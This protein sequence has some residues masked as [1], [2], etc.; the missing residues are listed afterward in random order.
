VPRMAR[1]LAPG[2][3]QTKR[4]P[5]DARDAARPARDD[6]RDP[7]DAARPTRDDVRD[8]RD[9]ARPTH[10]GA[11]DPRDLARPARDPRDAGRPTRDPRDRAAVRAEIAALERELAA[12]PLLELPAP[13]MGTARLLTMAELEAERARLE[14][15]LTRARGAAAAQGAAQERARVQL[16][17]MLL[18]PG[19]HRFERIYL[20]D[21]GEDG[22]G[23][24][25]VRPRLG[26]I[27][28]LMGWWHVKL[29]SGCPL[30]GPVARPSTLEI[31]GGSPRVCAPGSRGRRAPASVERHEN[32][33]Q[34]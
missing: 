9:A 28:M 17:R 4:P 30:P 29:S 20:S 16:E 34:P 3:P 5:R 1:T 14:Q 24:Y 31:P 22:C 7:R 21:L 25:S 19:R 27:G 33:H 15:R 10:D 2:A 23:A 6:A 12:L 26:L 18:A 13:R 32:D 8:P 11:R